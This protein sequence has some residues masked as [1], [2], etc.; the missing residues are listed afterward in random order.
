MVAIFMMR[1]PVVVSS[2]KSL[3]FSEK[4]HLHMYLC[5]V[6]HYR[7]PCFFYLPNLQNDLYCQ[8]SNISHTKFQNFKCFSSRFAVVFAE[9]IEARC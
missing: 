9:S 5:S 8:T 1:F 3:A 7:A 6:M 2:I 4:F